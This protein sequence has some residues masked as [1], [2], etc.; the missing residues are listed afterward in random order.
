MIALPH[1]SQPQKSRGRLLFE[2][3]QAAEGSGGT[4]EEVD[5]IVTKKQRRSSSSSNNS[6]SSSS[7][8]NVRTSSAVEQSTSTITTTIVQDTQQQSQHNREQNT[9]EL[10]R[11]FRFLDSILNEV[12]Q[13][14][15][16][17]TWKDIER[18]FESL[19]VSVGIT[20]VDL[21]CMLEIFP[22]AYS[23][24]LRTSDDAAKSPPV[25]CVTLNQ[26]AV[27]AGASRALNSESRIRQFRCVKH[28]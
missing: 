7:S 4:K 15:R 13:R 18:S 17:T 10:I 9:S 5:T 1:N 28:C 24:F 3:T 20:T 14:G 25:L 8:S 19:D 16:I 11:K 6:N 21:E 27:G 23:M 26:Q 22:T 2:K 12:N